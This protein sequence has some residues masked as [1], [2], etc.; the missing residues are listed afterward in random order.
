[1]PVPF[2]MDLFIIH[3]KKKIKAA[4]WTCT[5]VIQV[6]FHI[7]YFMKPLTSRSNNV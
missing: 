4:R 5:Y 2:I 6:T 1:M 3:N 7:Y